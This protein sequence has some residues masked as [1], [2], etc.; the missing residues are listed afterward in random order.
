MIHPVPL[1]P[2]PVESKLVTPS[3]TLPLQSTALRVQAAGGIARVVLEQ[4][5][6]NQHPDPLAVTYTFALPAEA[7][8]SGFAFAIGERRIEGQVEKRSAAREQFEQAIA[9][10][11]TAALFEQERSSLFRQELGNVPPGAEVRCEIVIDQ[12]LRW[13]DEG[14][15]E[16]R[17]PLAAAPRYL[18]G[19]DRVADREQIAF[20]VAATLAPR[21]SLQM[22]VADV[23]AAGATP[24]SPS[25][26][27]RPGDAGRIELDD[28]NQTALD[29]DLVVR[30][31][32]AGLAPSVHARAERSEQR[33]DAHALLTIVPPL[34]AAH[35]QS[36]ARDLI[37]L[38]DTSGSMQGEPL[39][40]ARRVAMALV[41]GL[42]DRDRVEL[43]E[44]SG[45][46]RRFRK[47]ALL[48]TSANKRAALEWLAKL[49]ASGGTEMRD[50]VLEALAPLRTEAQRQVVLITDGLIGFEQ[51][52]VQT[53]LEKLPRGSRVH[54]VGV[55]S[56]VNRS[57]TGP[58]A[59]AGRGVEVVIGLGEDPERAAARIRAR[60]EQPIVVDVELSGDALQEA[61]PACIPDLYA[62]APVLVS[63]RVRPE[64]GELVVSGRTPIG[65]WEQRVYVEPKSGSGLL[66]SL[67]G[68]EAVED[69]EM[70]LAAGADHEEI[71]RLVEKLGLQYR[72]ST[73]L[74]SWIAFD[75]TPS[76]DPRAPTR[77]ETVPQM[78]PHG[79]SIEGLGLRPAMHLALTARMAPLAMAAPMASAAPA[80]RGP[81]ARLSAHR[82]PQAEKLGLL[83]RAL[84]RVFGTAPV[85]D[86]PAEV[87]RGRIG[88]RDGKVV[89]IHLEVL[90]ELDWNESA[91][92]AATALIELDDGTTIEAKVVVA[93][94]TRG[95]RLLPGQHAKLVLELARELR[96]PARII[97]FDPDFGLYIPLA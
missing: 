26:R 30:W 17:F 29:R 47:T 83:N 16:W 69:A 88:K 91:L 95:G 37:V 20:E 27:I 49:R 59:R 19:A 87:A 32:V 78:L 21:A 25:H 92:A 11:K 57:L 60:T 56:S 64:G 86:K 13:I 55:G 40:Q 15:W 10:G 52:I 7:A 31:R 36:V 71:D 8:V 18:G 5:F 3:A 42:G 45:A 82:P 63:A 97:R 51:E 39:D 9:E 48:G 65:S 34:A 24:E 14:A 79:T 96:G 75:T 35:A 85:S 38:L 58:T 33:A 80:P 22:A 46:P 76:V 72:I 23:L 66:A 68:R 67:F 70:R 1:M 61:A 89:T 4:R 43:I 54:T 62:G 50:G 28:G 53:V 6:E 90:T 94:S 41:D 84:D 93:R 73:R 12:R 77:R 74:T 44:F 2:V 81:S